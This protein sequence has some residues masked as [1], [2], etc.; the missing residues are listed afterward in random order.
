M[1]AL[2]LQYS[3][4]GCD[5]QCNRYFHA[6]AFF[7]A[8]LLMTQ[9]LYPWLFTAKYW[10][11]ACKL[12]NIALK[13]SL[14]DDNL[15][16]S[17]V[18]YSMLAFIVV[19]P[20]FYGWLSW[21]FKY[22]A[23]LDF[24]YF[25]TQVAVFITVGFMV[26][27][28]RRYNK[29]ATGFEHSLNMQTLLILTFAYSLLLLSSLPYFITQLVQALEPSQNNEMQDTVVTGF[30]IGLIFTY[31]VVKLVFLK[32]LYDL[33]ILMSKSSSGGCKH[34]DDEQDFI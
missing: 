18:F 10:I 21:V 22:V 16:I 3:A 24:T 19:V 11:L 13:K 23:W 1:E 31:F 4:T 25:L 15:F 27:A 28:V 5:A 29:I 17:V 2:K 32:I 6:Q 7:L 14:D 33:Q 9:N 30:T 20:I 26:D 34:A 12:E 8:L